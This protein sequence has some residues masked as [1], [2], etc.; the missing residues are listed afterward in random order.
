MARL[1]NPNKK[2]YSWLGAMLIVANLIVFNALWNVAEP[3]Y[4]DLTWDKTHTLSPVTLKTI[5]DI[6]P[7]T[8]VAVDFYYTPNAVG[9]PQE[10]K[11]AGEEVRRI[12]KLYASAGKERLEIR[13]HHPDPLSDGKEDIAVMRQAHQQGIKRFEKYWNQSA[14]VVYCGIIA[15]FADR[16]Y[17]FDNIDAE[18]LSQLEYKITAGIAY[19]SSPK[20]KL[21]I[22]SG[23]DFRPK[24]LKDDAGANPIPE[25]EILTRL[26]EVFDVSFIDDPEGE[27]KDCDVLLLVSPRGLSDRDYQAIDEHVMQGK[28]AMFFES[29]FSFQE[30]VLLFQELRILESRLKDAME[31]DQQRRKGKARQDFLQSLKSLDSELY[32]LF[33]K[34]ISIET[35][36]EERDEEDMS[37]AQVKQLVDQQRRLLEILNSAMMQNPQLYQT[38]QGSMQKFEEQARPPRVPERGSKAAALHQELL[39]KQEESLPP[40]RMVN[41]DLFRKW[42]LNIV[43]RKLVFIPSPDKDKADLSQFDLTVGGLNGNPKCFV[44]NRLETKNL[45]ALYPSFT[46]A[47]QPW[48]EK[49]DIYQPLV[50]VNEQFFFFA[51]DRFVPERGGK[52]DDWFAVDSAASFVG[53]G[54]RWQMWNQTIRYP[55]DQISGWADIAVALEGKFDSAFPGEGSPHTVEGKQSRVAVVASVDILDIRPQNEEERRKQK[56]NHKFV[57][58][59]LK[60]LSLS[61][62]VAALSRREIDRFD[63][64]DRL[65]K[66]AA[67]RAENKREELEQRRDHRRKQAELEYERVKEKYP[68]HVLYEDIMGVM[69]PVGYHVPQQRTMELARADREYE[70]EIENLSLDAK[71]DIERIEYEV[72]T[73][74]RE[75]KA[76]IRFLGTFLPPALI[77]LL[78]LTVF[79]RQRFYGTKI[80]N[81]NR[82]APGQ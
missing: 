17:I 39:Q 76:L 33:Q 75:Q 29:N 1:F 44:Q 82:P 63:V 73:A 7:L 37:D 68:I 78:G 47:I 15:S 21:G 80:S 46:S 70:K 12:L 40:G 8:P 35:I 61:P 67:T 72:A 23:L 60:L 6:D 36:L 64:L 18:M 52:I 81:K 48:G 30:V 31:D 32:S 62:E 58:D 16:S 50:R 42:G 27:V 53:N 57:I 26:K 43:A 28:G 41:G 56:T 59:T 4:L 22:I 65:A 19:C 45:E 69:V 38:V 71:K 9:L 79:V 54:M 20:K 24:E 14:S 77:L 10:V 3:P 2:T 49:E 74:T 55:G 5:A 25:W 66:E 51:P 34:I 13:E 11:Q